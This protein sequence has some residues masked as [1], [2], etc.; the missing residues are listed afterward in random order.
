MRASLLR[1]RLS[2]DVRAHCKSGSMPTCPTLNPAHSG[3][4]RRRSRGSRG[5]RLQTAPEARPP[6]DRTLAAPMPGAR[7]ALQRP[8]APR[9][10]TSGAQARRA[11]RGARARPARLGPA[12]VL[13]G[14]QLW[15]LWG[16]LKMRARP[17]MYWG[18]GLRVAMCMDGCPGRRRSARD[19]CSCGARHRPPRPRRCCGGRGQRGRH[20]RRAACA[21]ARG[22]RRAA[23]PAPGAGHAVDARHRAVA[24]RAR[25]V[26][27]RQGAP[28]PARSAGRRRRPRRVV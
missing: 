16:F 8:P 25:P 21:R 23:G 17:G 28:R 10:G 13:Q 15:L 4:R 9:P 22:R 27:A 14:L 19:L 7:R 26:R 18:C 11:A 20:G 3:A 6:L 12:Q 24:R 5:A 2:P 1:R